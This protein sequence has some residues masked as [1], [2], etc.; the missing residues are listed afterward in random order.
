MRLALRRLHSFTPYLYIFYTDSTFPTLPTSHTPRLSLYAQRL[1]HAVE[2]VTKCHLM[3]RLMGFW[4]DPTWRAM[5]RHTWLTTT[6]R[7][8]R[9]AH[10]LDPVPEST[11][12][13]KARLLRLHEYIL[14]DVLARHPY[15]RSLTPRHTPHTPGWLAFSSEDTARP[16]ALHFN[17]SPDTRS[18]PHIR[19]G[20]A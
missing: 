18:T 17:S 1:Q 14:P 13:V 4:Y 10:R 15:P 7:L 6:V 19:V 16:N 8:F 5:R 20:F 2:D 9:L 3:T 12:A 11:D